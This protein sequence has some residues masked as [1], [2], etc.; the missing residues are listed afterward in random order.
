LLGDVRGHPQRG[1]GIEETRWRR[2]TTPDEDEEEGERKG[3]EKKSQVKLKTRQDK[4]SGGEGK[5][6]SCGGGVE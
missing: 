6:W 2:R 4:R 3:G 1:Q 5:V